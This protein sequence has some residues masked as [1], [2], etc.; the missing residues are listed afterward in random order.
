MVENRLDVLP[1]SELEVPSELYVELVLVNP[2][3]A[4]RSP[5][6]SADVKTSDKSLLSEVGCSRVSRISG[7]DETLVP[8]PLSVSGVDGS[9]VPEDPLCSDSSALIPALLLPASAVCSALY[10]DRLL[11]P[12]KVVCRACS[13]PVSEIEPLELA[14]GME[15][16]IARS[17][18]ALS[19]AN[20][21]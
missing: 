14:P 1:E 6:A 19:L 18:F 21:A 2:S 15:S 5:D 9:L 8:D 20:S 4:E 3:S 17:V 13:M 11:S 16:I 12:S 7:C 10:S